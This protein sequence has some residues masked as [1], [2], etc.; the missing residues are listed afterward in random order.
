[1]FVLQVCVQVS[2]VCVWKTTFLE[3]ECKEREIDSTHCRVTFNCCCG[4]FFAT[5]SS[6]RKRNVER[7]I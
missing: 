4:D 7:E 1:M 6:F 3:K 5:S 2:N